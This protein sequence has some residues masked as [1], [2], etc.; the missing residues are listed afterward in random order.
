ME[1]LPF[2][3]GLSLAIDHAPAAL[4]WQAK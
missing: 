3:N 4:E 1:N 2:W